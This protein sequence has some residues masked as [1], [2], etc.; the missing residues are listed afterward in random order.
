MVAHICKHNKTILETQHN[1]FETQVNICGK[2]Q[3]IIE[4]QHRIL[5]TQHKILLDNLVLSTELK[6]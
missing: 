2:Q 6:M 3:K 5:E 4:T 1:S